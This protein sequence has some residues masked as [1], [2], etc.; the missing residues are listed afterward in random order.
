MEHLSGRVAAGG[1]TEGA[2]EDAPKPN[3]PRHRGG[4]RKKAHRRWVTAWIPKLRESGIQVGEG[5]P[6]RDGR[7]QARKAVIY[8][9]SPGGRR[10]SGLCA[11][12][13]RLTPSSCGTRRAGS[14]RSRRCHRRPGAVQK[15]SRRLSRNFCETTAGG[16]EQEAEGAPGRLPGVPSAFRVHGRRTI[17][18]R[19]RRSRGGL[20]GKALTSTP[21]PHEHDSIRPL[22]P[23]R[24]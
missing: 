1:V 23:I 14:G 20:L 8:V 9:Q 19:V 11:C 15:L 21:P 5:C 24:R 2:P 7:R 22:L 18:C 17:S 6:R 3:T 12:W 13:R 10:P 16:G 4:S